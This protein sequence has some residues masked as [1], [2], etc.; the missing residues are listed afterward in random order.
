MPPGSVPPELDAFLSLDGPQ[1]LLIRGLPGTGKTSLAVGLLQRFQGRRLFVTSRV[2]P[3]QLRRQFPWLREG[4]DD[5]AS[6]VSIIDSFGSEGSVASSARVVAHARD[7]LVEP[8]TGSGGPATEFLWLPDAVQESLERI[9]EEHPT[10]LVFDSWDA[11]VE[12][13]LGAPIPREVPVPDRDAVE[14]FLLRRVHAAGAHLVLVVE[15]EVA[16]HLDYLVDGVV[17]TARQFD[18]ERLER[19]LTLEKLRRVRIGEAL[20]PFTLE[21]GRFACIDPLPD[22]WPT[23]PGGSPPDP[24]PA[25]DSV[26]PGN[27]SFAAEFGRLPI[28]QLTVVEVEA[29]LPLSCEHRLVIP[30]LLSVLSDG[31]RVVLT[32]PPTIR[33]EEIY[34]QVSAFV[35]RRVIR[36]RLRLFC[37]EARPSRRP[38]VTQIVVDRSPP[39]DL[40]HEVPVHSELE[41][42]LSVPAPEGKANLFIDSLTNLRAFARWLGTDLSAVTMPAAL[43]HFLTLTPCAGVVVGSPGDPVLEALLSLAG[44]HI[45]VRERHGRAVAYGV[46][47]RTSA[48]VLTQPMP[49]SSTAPS[50][51]LRRIV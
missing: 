49:A 38:E 23:D 11:L 4:R 43:Q 2:D 30:M 42:F 41:A 3:L 37:A 18:D 21:G 39:L 48:F 32:P 19:W 31:G 16:S 29:R 7:V 44:L 35:S 33:A 51:E 27:A 6:E 22:R 8:E 9:D 1:S 40:T 13:F 24:A 50:Y 45:R 46:R 15:R 25:P 20:Y 28:G 10:L 36:E 12:Q 17:S 14:R 5:A 47:P 34:D 26:W